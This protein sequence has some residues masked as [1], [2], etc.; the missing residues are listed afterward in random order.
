MKK[1]KITFTTLMILFSITLWSQVAINTDESDPDPSAMLDVKSTTSGEQIAL[2]KVGTLTYLGEIQPTKDIK[3]LRINTKDD[4]ERNEDIGKRNFPFKETSLPQG[5]DPVI[6]KDMGK[7]KFT[8]ALTKNFNGM[9]LAGNPTDPNGDVGPNHYFHTTNSGYQIFD[10]QGNL[11]HQGDMPDIWDTAVSWSDPVVLYDDNADRWL[12]G[13]LTIGDENVGIPYGILIAVS[14]SSDPLGSY[15]A[16]SLPVTYLPDFPKFG[17]WHNGY[18]LATNCEIQEDVFVVERDMMLIGSPVVSYVGFDNPWRPSSGLHCIMPLDNDGIFAPVGT[19]GQFI[20][21]NDDAWGGGNDELWVYELDVDWSNPYSA[22]F[23]R[24]QQILVASFDSNFDSFWEAIPQQETTQM[25]ENLT[26]SLN[27]RAQYRNFG[28]YQTIVCNHAV[29]INHNDHSGIRWYELRNYGSGWY[30]YQQS[31]YAPDEHHRFFGAIAMNAAGDVGLAYS[32]SSNTLYPSL[33][34]TG[35]KAGDPLGTMT[36]A[37]QSIFEGTAS[38]TANCRWGDYFSMSIDPTDNNTFW[39]AGEYFGTSSSTRIAAFNLESTCSAMGGCDEYIYSVQIGDINNTS[40]CNGYSDFR[41]MVTDIPLSSVQSLTIT[42]GNPY[43][44]DQCAVWVDWNRD[45]DFYDINENITVAGSPGLGPYT[46]NIAPPSETMQGPCILRIRIIYTGILD[47]CGTTTW[48][49][50]EDYTINLVPEEPNIWTGNYNTSWDVDS[51]WSLGHVPIATEDVEVYAGLH[52]CWISDA[53]AECRNLM[54]DDEFGSYL[55]LTNG[56][57]LHIYGN[58]NIYGELMI[59]NVSSSFIADENINWYAG[60]SA[61][62]SADA[63]IGLGGDWTFFEGANVHLDQGR[64]TFWGGLNPSLIKCNDSA[65]YFNTL[66]IWKDWVEIHSTSTKDLLIKGRVNIYPNCVL[67][68]TSSHSIILEDDLWYSGNYNFSNGSVVFQGNSQEIRK[69]LAYPSASGT[70]NNLTI[71]SGISTDLLNDSIKINGNLTIQ[72]GQLNPNSFTIEVGGNWNNVVGADG[73]L[74]GTGRVVFNG[75]NYIQYCSDEE[76]NIL[77]LNKPSG[78]DL[79][80][81]YEYVAC[82]QYDWNAGNIVVL[83]GSFTALSLADNGIFGGYY[84]NQGGE[85][86]LTQL[87]PWVDIC[88]DIYIDGGTINIYGG[89]TPS[90]WPYLSDASVTILDGVLDF[91]D[92]GIYI[93]N[94]PYTLTENITGG[95]IIVN[96]GFWGED[97]A[98]SPQGG[99]MEFVGDLTNSIYTIYGNLYNVVVNKTSKNKNSKK[100]KS[101]QVIDKRSG[102]VVTDGTKSNTLW[103]GDYLDIHG[104][105][106]IENGMLYTNGEDMGV[107]GN[108][109]N[110]VGN[111]GFV[112]DT[113]TVFLNGPNAADI[114]TD[115]TFYDLNIDKTYEP[116]DGVEIATLK[117][118][119]VLNELFV[120]NGTLEIDNAATLDVAGDVFIGLEAGINAGGED[121]IL[122]IRVGGNFTDENSFYDGKRG[123]TPG[124]ETITFYGTGDKFLT[125]NAPYEEFNNLRI[126]KDAFGTF[127]PNSNVRVLGDMEIASSSWWDNATGLTHEFLGDFSVLSNG[128]YFPEGTTAFTGSS[129][130]HFFHNGG[131][132]MQTLV[133]DKTGSSSLLL[134]GNFAVYYG[135]TTTVQ[136][137][138]FNLNGNTFTSYGDT[139]INNN[140]KIIVPASSSL[141]INTNLFVTGNGCLQTI[142]NAD[143]PANVFHPSNGYYGLEVSN[144]GTISAEYAHF[145]DM[146]SNGIKIYNGGLVDE[147]HAFNHCTI[148]AGQNADYAIRLRVYNNQILTCTDVNFPNN[149]GLPD[150]FNVGKSLYVF[151]HLNFVNATGDFAG[152]SYEADPFGY[153]DWTTASVDLSLSSMLEGPFNGSNMSTNLNSTG[154]LP[155]SQPFNKPPWNYSGGEL[156]A[157]IPPDAVDWVLVELRDAMDATSATPQSRLTRQAGFLMS[158]GSVKGVDGVSSLV[159]N[160]VAAHNLYAIVWHRNHLGIMSAYPLSG[161][162]GRYS[163]DFTVNENM[164]YGGISGHKNLDPNSQVYS[165]TTTINSG[166]LQFYKFVNG[167]DWGDV[168]TVPGDCGFE[169][170]QGGNNRVLIVPEKDTVLDATCFSSCYP[171]GGSSNTVNITFRVDMTSQ[172]VSTNGVHLAGTFQSWDPAATEMLPVGNNIYAVTVQLNSGEWETYKF[173]NGNAWG[174]EEVVPPECAIP[175]GYGNRYF[176]VPENDISLEPVCF[177]ECNSCGTTSYPVTVTFRVDMTGQTISPNGVHV[178]GSFQSWDPAASEMIPG[179][180]GMIAGDGDANGEVNMNDK[181]NVWILQAGEEGYKSGD[182]NLDGQVNNPDKNDLLLENQ[183]RQSQVPQ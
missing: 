131:G 165:F 29:D 159:F 181:T 78:N 113:G 182:F 25:L 119:D 122:T 73:F 155:L 157:T 66:N 178:T 169:D 138:I 26:S 134:D 136:N 116:F 84:V 32:V 39:F 142:G 162:Q 77:E 170:G 44:Q 158:D 83:S 101:K 95:T 132:Q 141:Y 82:N 154:I 117:S 23:N 109:T 36:V 126:E 111:V 4:F 15:Y 22:T 67:K 72:S 177:S 151:G 68:S 9:I 104:D 123:F 47:P 5:S 137:G 6:Q 124:G 120:N 24:T 108:W 69:D 20:T 97:P 130:Q 12:V 33:R 60:A 2:P 28:S 51:N 175:D 176:I 179:V 52:K 166:T 93:W 35:R 164:V 55:K 75:G 135:Y 100:S 14:A 92:Q 145:E 173:I 128:N 140:G 7:Q 115:E 49:E 94:G 50:V 37:E 90:F 180:W 76:F 152:S 139:Y 53:D 147:D 43:P 57:D 85:I 13:M 153:I 91:H 148:D 98:F 38:Q 17:V 107:G 149:P 21:I 163:F 150:R 48:G 59:D 112:A 114:L 65:C 121:T 127:R 172:T 42:N 3:S 71:A 19:P 81:D 171:C 41:A 174:S 27:Y 34:Y 89:E 8:D 79:L 31:T 62:I 144:G 183:T 86:N 30:P 99:T 102:K 63:Q 125:A 56:Y 106:T 133:I 74:E 80:I 18:Y 103:L 10:K 40:A 143:N 96:G 110:N 16:Y 87:K 45:G 161:S 156:A 146:N 70:F 118:V 129:D 64:V 160:D 168:E 1:I 88:G 61:D 11:L 46:A 54:I 58:A 105:L 167:N